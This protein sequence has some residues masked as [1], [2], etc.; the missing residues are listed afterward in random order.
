VT[1]PTGGSRRASGWALPWHK[2]C[3]LWCNGAEFQNCISMRCSRVTRVSFA[4]SKRFASF[5]PVAQPCLSLA[6]R[7]ARVKINASTDVGHA[8]WLWVIVLFA[9]VMGVLARRSRAGA[10]VIRFV[11]LIVVIGAAPV[12]PGKQ[13]SRTKVVWRWGAVV[14]ILVAT[15]TVA[16]LSCCRT[17]RLGQ[18]ELKPLPDVCQYLAS[19]EGVLACGVWFGFVCFD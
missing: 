4:N 14:T 2:D 8:G 11:I 12:L 13:K 6:L 19:L 9:W 17:S 10:S 5:L 15:V 18:G 7:Q 16:G 3:W 1:H